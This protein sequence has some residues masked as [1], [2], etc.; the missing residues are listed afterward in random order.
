MVGLERPARTVVAEVARTKDSSS[1]QDSR[2]A[3]HVRWFKSDALVI[4]VLALQPAV[5]TANMF[6]HSVFLPR[7]TSVQAVINATR[8]EHKVVQRCSSTQWW[9]YYNSYDRFVVGLHV[10][11]VTRQPSSL[12]LAC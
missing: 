9:H 12:L 5:T 11:I 10:L 1:S 7:R 2:A 8:R 6:G 4:I 3:S